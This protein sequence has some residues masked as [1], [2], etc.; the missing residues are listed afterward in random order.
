[1][2]TLPGHHEERSDVAVFHGEIAAGEDALAM[3]PPPP[4]HRE[5]RSDVAVFL[6]S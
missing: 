2:A 4:G 5:E 6:D 1:M 3:T